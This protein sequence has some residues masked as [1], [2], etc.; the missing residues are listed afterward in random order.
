MPQLAE[1]ELDY[2]SNIIPLFPT[3]L[4]TSFLDCNYWREWDKTGF[5]LRQQIAK[6][7]SDYQV[8]ISDGKS[9]SEAIFEWANETKEDLK[10]FWLEYL[11]QRLVLP[12]KIEKKLIDGKWEIIAPLYGNLPLV[13]TVLEEERNGATKKGIEKITDFLA[14]AP[15]GSTAILISPSGWSGLKND[16]DEKIIYTETQIY[17][18]QVNVFGQI[19]A[20]TIR[21]DN[22]LSQNAALLL[23]LSGCQLPTPNYPEL[24]QIIIENIVKNPILNYGTEIA[25]NFENIIKTIQQTKG[26]PFVLKNRTFIELWEQFSNRRQISTLSADINLIIEGFC[27]FVGAYSHLDE[28]SLET[29]AKK[30]EN[31]LRR[32]FHSERKT[33]LTVKDLSLT[34]QQRDQDLAEIQ[35]L[36]GCVGIGSSNFSS[37]L[38]TSLGIRSYTTETEK[39]FV[40][41]CGNCGAPINARISKGYVCPHCGGVYEG[42]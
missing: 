37:V 11:C 26:S 1:R 5:K 25:T 28:E 15:A 8:K 2:S 3:E 41:N 22:T 13:K 36:F 14:S 31:T 21:A 19:E 40:K 35:R 12:I 7:V 4:D 27:S 10:G 24:N 23:T 30:L 6:L 20:I 38:F 33:S 29:I 18:Y 9:P 34:I 32:L 39:K 42:C 16:L 17:I